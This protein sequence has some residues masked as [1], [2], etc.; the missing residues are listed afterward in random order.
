MCTRLFACVV[1][2]AVV[3]LPWLAPVL[4][5]GPVGIYGIVTLQEHG[6]HAAIVSALRE[7]PRR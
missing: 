7:A 5:S 2:A 6:S 4:A 1:T 3:S